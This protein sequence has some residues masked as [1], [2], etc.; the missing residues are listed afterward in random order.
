M[1]LDV[2]SNSFEPAFESVPRTSWHGIDDNEMAAPGHRRRLT[3]YRAPVRGE[4]L[5]I[6]EEFVP[7]QRYWW[8]GEGVTVPDVKIFMNQN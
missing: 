6:V 1:G 5:N 4:A 3:R 7:K 2:V 8:R